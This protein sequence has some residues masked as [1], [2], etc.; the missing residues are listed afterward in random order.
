MKCCKKENNYDLMSFGRAAAAVVG[1]GGAV[2]VPPAA[3]CHKA[4]KWLR[5]IAEGNSLGAAAQK[6]A[7]REG[8]AR[9]SVAGLRNTEPCS[10]LRFP[11]LA[12]RRERKGG[13]SLLVFAPRQGRETVGEEMLRAARPAVPPPH[14]LFLGHAFVQW[15]QMSRGWRKSTATMLLR[16]KRPLLRWS[17]EGVS[18]GRVR[19]T[20]KFGAG[21]QARLAGGPAA[22]CRKRKRKGK[23]YPFVFPFVQMYFPYGFAFFT[24]N[25]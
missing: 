2:K 20:C 10:P 17:M 14:P 13:A 25:E 18:G 8:D 12:V 11:C 22:A 5:Q 3:A 23:T 6:R 19:C 21:G 24:E 1:D 4:A 15:H 7:R 16:N 9:G